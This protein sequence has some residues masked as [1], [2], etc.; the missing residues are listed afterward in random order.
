M[1]L[2]GMSAM[3]SI[4]LAPTRRT[5]APGESTCG[6]CHS[7]QINTGPG[8]VSL[9]APADYRPGETYTLSLSI[10]DSLVPVGRFGFSTTMLDAANLRAG[11]VQLTDL[12]R[13]SLQT[14]FVSGQIRQYLG[15]AQADTTRHWSW[16]WT[17]P[18]AGTGPVTLYVSAVV[19]NRNTQTTGDRVYNRTFT[20]PENTTFP[21]AAFSLDTTALCVGGSVVATDASGGTIDTYAWDF[22]AG[23]QPQTA[24][25][26]GPHVV[27]FDSP[28]QYAV[29][30]I[31]SSTEGSDTLT[32]TLTVHPQPALAVAPDTIRQCERDTPQLL[33][34]LAA[35]A[36]G[37]MPPYSYAWSCD[38]PARCGLGTP[39]QA[40]PQALPAWLPGPDTL[41]Y[42]LLLTDARGCQA[43]PATWVATQAAAP[44]PEIVP[45]GDSLFCPT[46]AALYSW[47]L[48]DPQDSSLTYIPAATEPYFFPGNLAPGHTGQVVVEALYANGCN[49]RSEPVAIPGGSTS[50]A[51]S[52]PAGLLVYPQPAAEVVHLRW[53]SAPSRAWHLRLLSPG[54]QVVRQQAVSPGPGASLSLQGLPSGLYLLEVRQGPRTYYR[55]LM[56]W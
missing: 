9:N 18:P 47:A 56:H 22:G 15:H 4:N 10:A 26:P 17:A 48:F 20:L 25:T 8:S 35:Q 50:L 23:A 53:T 5:G 55:K 19:A 13:T 54:G 1:V 51:D 33:T 24:D 28:G 32:Q 6:S 30:L 7:G 27:T 42:Q 49:R 40:T 16:Q 11:T 52:W 38:D 21:Q 46:P 3:L 29:R 36:Q 43:A 31:V 14:G 45:A 41:R 37:G 12:L 2:L 34:A 44:V 39:D